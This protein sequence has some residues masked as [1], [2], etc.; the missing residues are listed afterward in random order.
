MSNRV[1]QVTVDLTSEQVQIVSQVPGPLNDTTAKWIMGLLETPGVLGKDVNVL[2]GTSTTPSD[3]A[4]L[5]AALE[6][7]S[8]RRE[9]AALGVKD[10]ESIIAS[11]TVW[12][13]YLE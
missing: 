11:Q 8:C 7:H 13:F 5:S 6:D 9:L 4:V 3:Q 12:L 10:F 1:V 2:T